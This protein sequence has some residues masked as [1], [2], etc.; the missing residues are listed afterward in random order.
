MLYLNICLC[1]YKIF[2]VVYS[3]V[4]WELGKGNDF[5]EGKALL[6]THI[7]ALKSYPL[8]P[9]LFKYFHLNT[10]MFLKPSCLS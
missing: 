6:A 7:K 9:L 2:Y 5:G 1:R 3:S 4:S 10:N 8:Y